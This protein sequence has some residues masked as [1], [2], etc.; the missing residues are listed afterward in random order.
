MQARE[1]WKKPKKRAAR[2]SATSKQLFF[3]APGLD[4]SHETIALVLTQHFFPSLTVQ[5]LDDLNTSTHVNAHS[6]TVAVLLS[7]TLR[8]LVLKNEVKNRLNQLITN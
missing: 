6:R 5:T 4:A 3:S 8:W 1:A 7:Y 2:H